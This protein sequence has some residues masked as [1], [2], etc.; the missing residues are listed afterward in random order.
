MKFNELTANDFWEEE[1]SFL[2]QKTKDWECEIIL[3]DTKRS[4]EKTET[5][6]PNSVTNFNESAKIHHSQ[7]N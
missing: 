4:N 7:R 1:K 3:I 6:T 2:I 5:T